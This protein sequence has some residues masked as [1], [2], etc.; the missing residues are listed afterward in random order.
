MKICKMQKELVFVE[1]KELLN[2]ANGIRRNS[3]Q[4]AKGLDAKNLAQDKKT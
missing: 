1:I 3:S 4:D 2:S